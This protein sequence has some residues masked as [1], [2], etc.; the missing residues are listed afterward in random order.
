MDADF[1]SLL[2]DASGEAHSKTQPPAS[3]APLWA[4]PMPLSA[5]PLGGPLA[6][7]AAELQTSA[8]GE[9]TTTAPDFDLQPLS[10]NVRDPI[11]MTPPRIPVRGDSCKHVQCFDLG[12][13]IIALM[14]TGYCLDRRVFSRSHVSQAFLVINSLPNARWKCPVCRS[15]TLPNCESG[16]TIYCDLQ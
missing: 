1:A 8:S 6:P 3:T 7:L 13:R 5:P 4:P 12:V 2:P 10:I 9:S 15:V 14:H 16:L 11:T